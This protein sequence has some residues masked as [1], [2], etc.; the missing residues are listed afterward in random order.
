[1]TRLRA[2]LHTH[3][4]AWLVTSV[5]ALSASFA[6]CSRSGNHAS[7]VPEDRCSNEGRFLPAQGADDTAQRAHAHTRELARTHRAK[8]TFRC[9]A[10][11]G[12]TLPRDEEL[13]IELRPDIASMCERSSCSQLRIAEHMPLRSA[14]DQPCRKV[15]AMLATMSLRTNAGMLDEPVFEHNLVLD[16][17]ELAATYVI[18][19]NLTSLRRAFAVVDADKVLLEVSL[20]VKGGKLGGGLRAWLEVAE[21]VSAEVRNVRPLWEAELSAH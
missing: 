10:G 13:T 15:V 18:S 11:D 19:E 3:T 21:P 14:H 2:C 8:L 7:A 17:D 1:M 16:G 9:G 4:R 12:C 6:G 20:Q 5:L